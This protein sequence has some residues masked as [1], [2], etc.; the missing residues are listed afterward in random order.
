MMFSA[1]LQHFSRLRRAFEKSIGLFRE[2]CA[3]KFK[4]REPDSRR[5]NQHIFAISQPK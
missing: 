2:K 1:I 3:R 4:S 5:E